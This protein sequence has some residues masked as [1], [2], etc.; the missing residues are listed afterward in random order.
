[1]K[2]RIWTRKQKQKLLHDLKSNIYTTLTVVETWI[3]SCE[4]REQLQSIINFLD[5]KVSQYDYILSSYNIAFW[6]TN[7]IYNEVKEY[8]FSHVKQLEENYTGILNEINEYEIELEKSQKS[9]PTIR[10][11]EKIFYE[12]EY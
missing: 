4:N 2:K 9:A 10:G 12:E 1:M 6:Y 11:F 3:G 7:S 5:R 8:L